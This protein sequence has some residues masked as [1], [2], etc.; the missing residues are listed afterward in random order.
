MYLPKILTG[1]AMAAAAFAA[2]AAHATITLL[3]LEDPG[4]G[5]TSY[6]LNFTA[7]A[8]STTLTIVGY[9]V[10]A[11]ETSTFNSVTPTAGGGNLLGAGWAFSPA[12]CGSVA[13]QFA[14]GSG[15]NELEFLG[16]FEDSFDNYSQ[17]FATTPGTSYTVALTFTDYHSGPSGFHVLVD[18]SAVPEPASWAFML[19]GVG[20]LG[21]V[22]HRRRSVLVAAA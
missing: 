3:D 5:A 6:S 4:Y 12:P 9:Q 15:V 13:G 7:S 2:T 10:P 11:E 22:M 21:A 19:V 1:I 20:G 14:D 17:T 16:V 18:A 8:G